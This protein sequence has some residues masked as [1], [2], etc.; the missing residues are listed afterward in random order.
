MAVIALNSPKGGVAKTTLAILLA[1]ECAFKG[2]SVALLDADPNQHAALFGERSTVPGLDFQGQI[3]DQNVIQSIRQTSKTYDLVFLDLPGAT[4][5]L[6]L[7][8][9]QLSDYVILP[10]Q[11]SRP[12]VRD[13]MRGIQQIA[14]A[15]DLKGLP[16]DETIP[17]SI[18]WT[19]IPFSFESKAARSIREAIAKTG[20]RTM[21]SVLH[22]RAVYKEMHINSEVPRQIDPNSA[23]TREVS[24]L[25]DELLEN[26][27]KLKETVDA[28]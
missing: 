8:A 18:L 13:A 10:C 11:T 4:T 19:R 25:A 28:A 14:E 24:T 20:A 2:H 12:D 27:Y 17:Y 1:S 16:E 9:L 15:G 22:E 7:K 23:A 5:T 21:G 6:N 3:T 26:L